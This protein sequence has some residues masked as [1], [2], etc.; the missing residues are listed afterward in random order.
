MRDTN[1]TLRLLDANTLRPLPEHIAADGP[2][3]VEDKAGSEFLVKIVCLEPST[4][5]IA[6]PL[7]VDERSIGYATQLGPDENLTAQLGLIKDGQQIIAG[8]T[9]TTHAFKLRTPA[10]G[11]H[12]SSRGGS[13]HVTW[14]SATEPMEWRLH[15]HSCGGHKRGRRCARER[16]RFNA[17][18][19][20]RRRQNEMG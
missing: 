12:A 19:E 17:F 20:C 1:H 16:G 5:S 11:A 15:A 10:A 18:R 3:W 6:Y 9:I 4:R 13:V 7:L 2:T 14:R 8:G